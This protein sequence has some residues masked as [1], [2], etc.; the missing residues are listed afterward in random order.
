MEELQRRTGP[1]VVTGLVRAL[2]SDRPEVVNR[3]AW[4]LANLDA[5]EAVP[6]L[7]P[8]LVTVRYKVVWVPTG[9]S[10]SD[11]FGVSFG[12]VAAAPGVG[13][14]RC[15]VERQLDRRADRPGGRPRLGRL[16]RDLRPLPRVR[17][18]RHRD[19]RRHSGSRGPIPMR[20]PVSYQNVEVLSALVKLTGRDFGYDRA[21]WRNWLNTSFRPD[22][23]PVRRVPQP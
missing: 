15:A 8:A 11:G 7:I 6:K 12:S 13:E 20:V 18:H 23:E 5:V 9:P 22:P 19:R 21:A 17:D 4:A 3:A 2:G 1:I 10:R 16:R 14:R